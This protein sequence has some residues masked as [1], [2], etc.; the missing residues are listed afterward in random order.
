MRA[1]DIEESTFNF[2]GFN[3]FF[4]VTIKVRSKDSATNTNTYCSSS[5]YLHY[6]HYI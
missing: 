5:Q 1:N 2:Y 4:V 6:L 3:F